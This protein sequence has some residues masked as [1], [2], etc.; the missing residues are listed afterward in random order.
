MTTKDITVD[1]N[2]TNNTTPATT[3]RLLLVD[4]GTNALQDITLENLLKVIND[5]TAEASPVTGSDYVVIYSASSGAPRKV[6]L[7]NLGV[8]GSGGGSN[9]SSVW[10]AG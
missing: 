2:L 9:L 7:N 8:G 5:L 6:L 1:G 3:D 10:V 4:A